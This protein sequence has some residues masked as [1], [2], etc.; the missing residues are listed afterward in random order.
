[1]PHPHMIILLDI[2]NFR[3][4]IYEYMTNKYVDY[5]KIMIILTF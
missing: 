1:V 2:L 4:N 3:R 5:I